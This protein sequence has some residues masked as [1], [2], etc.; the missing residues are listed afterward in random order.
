[1]KKNNKNKDISFLREKFLLDFCKNKGWN[2]NELTTGQMLVII[3]EK[4]YR[5]PY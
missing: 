2:P 1:M 3:N 5:N 4:G